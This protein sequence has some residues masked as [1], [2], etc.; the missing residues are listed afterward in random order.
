VLEDPRVAPV[1]LAPP[2]HRGLVYHGRALH[3]VLDVA[4]RYG[5]DAAPEGKNVLLLDAGGAGVGVVA[6]R[7][8]GV[9]E[10]TGEIFRPPWDALF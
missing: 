2:S 8:L 5:I 1:P 3:P 7:V 10:G 4:I 6:D 9:A